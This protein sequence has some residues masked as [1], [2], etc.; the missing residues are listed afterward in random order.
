MIKKSLITLFTLAVLSI[1][2]LPVTAFATAHEA[3]SNGVD[4]EMELKNNEK[5]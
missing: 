1:N 3:N 2:L 5:N 4:K